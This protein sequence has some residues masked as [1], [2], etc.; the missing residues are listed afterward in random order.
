MSRKPTYFFPIECIPLSSCYSCHSPLPCQQPQII[1]HIRTKALYKL[2]TT[3]RCHHSTDLL[4]KRFLFAC[5]PSFKAHSSN[6]HHGIRLSPLVSARYSTVYGHII[7]LYY[8]FFSVRP[9]PVSFSTHIIS[10]PLK[11]KRSNQIT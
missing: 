4:K 11:S 9:L 5:Y 6:S 2:T 10:T 1:V 7:T 8:Y 3:P